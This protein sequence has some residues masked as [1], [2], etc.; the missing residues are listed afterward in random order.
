MR[1]SHRLSNMIKLFFSF[2]LLFDF[3][4]LICR[5]VSAISVN[6]RIHVREV[7]VTVIDRSVHRFLRARNRVVTWN[8]PQKPDC[9]GVV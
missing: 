7:P 4:F 3:S 6:L 2:Y 5:S 9:I 1:E 8:G